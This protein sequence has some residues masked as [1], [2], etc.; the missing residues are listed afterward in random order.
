MRNM[1]SIIFA[2]LAFSVL[3]SGVVLGN[4]L[5]WD[6]SISFLRL[7]PLQ[8]FSIVTAEVCALVVGVAILT[9]AH[10]L[11]WR[12]SVLATLVALTASYLIGVLIWVAAFQS[13]VLRFTASSLAGLAVFV[14]PE[15]IG[16][17]IGSA[18]IERLLKTQRKV[19]LT[20]MTAAV[21]TSLTISVLLG[22]LHAM[23]R[24]S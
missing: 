4:P 13:G 24:L 12:K 5:L 11:A 10:R 6:P 20:T 21:I 8:Y 9:H 3:V 1:F 19:A 22:V 23:L 16:I 18:I 17:L 7:E 2:L 15:I 14:L